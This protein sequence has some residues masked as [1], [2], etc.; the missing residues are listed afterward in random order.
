MRSHFSR[1]HGS[2]TSAAR[3]IA[4]Q[5]LQ[6]P[7]SAAPS[8]D[9]VMPLHLALIMPEEL[10]VPS[11][12]PLSCSN[13]FHRY[14]TDFSAA[15]HSVRY[16]CGRGSVTE[17][18]LVGP[19]EWSTAQRWV[20]EDRSMATKH[21]LGFTQCCFLCLSKDISY[22]FVPAAEQWK[23]PSNSLFPLMIFAQI[24]PCSNSPFSEISAAISGQGHCELK[25]SFVRKKEIHFCS[26]WC[27]YI[28]PWWPL[29]TSRTHH[30]WLPL[31]F[32]KKGRE[33]SSRSNSDQYHHYMLYGVSAMCDWAQ[34]KLF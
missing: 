19:A 32:S 30:T 23:R 29:T 6:D 24:I 20:P 12:F 27:T 10:F 3:N 28:L 21:S 4:Q 11:F 5:L 1:S 8:Q 26:K 15:T 18:G 33:I 13:L 9:F 17:P 2:G 34:W 16:S 7:T 31:Q 22:I 25:F 14:F